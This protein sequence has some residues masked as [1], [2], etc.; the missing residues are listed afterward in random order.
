MLIVPTLLTRIVGFK[1]FAVLSGFSPQNEVAGDKFR[2]GGTGAVAF[3]FA[4]LELDI[5][6]IFIT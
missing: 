3:L 5:M 6:S 4:H 1:V 2:V